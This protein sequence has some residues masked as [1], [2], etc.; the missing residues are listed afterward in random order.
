MKHVWKT[1]N[2]R[3]GLISLWKTSNTRRNSG[4]GFSKMLF[5]SGFFLILYVIL[6]E[7]IV[8]RSKTKLTTHGCSRNFIHDYGFLNVKVSMTSSMINPW[9]IHENRFFSRLKIEQVGITQSTKFYGLWWLWIF[10]GGVVSRTISET[11]LERIGQSL[12]YR[13][14]LVMI[15]AF[16]STP[17]LVPDPLGS[18]PL[19]AILLDIKLKLS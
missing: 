5:K 1:L 3:W 17:L 12:R 9:F 18:L 4:S 15:Y 7:N 10:L 11:L 19:A 13:L 6:W 14:L 16:S 8:E 2:Q